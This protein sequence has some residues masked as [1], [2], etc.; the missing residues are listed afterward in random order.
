M[1]EEHFDRV[2]SQAELEQEILESIHKAESTH[3]G[4]VYNDIG[5][6][7][8]KVLRSSIVSKAAVRHTPENYQRQTMNHML[9]VSETLTLVRL[10]EKHFP[11]APFLQ[12]IAEQRGYL[13]SLIEQTCDRNATIMGKL[14]Q[15]VLEAKQQKP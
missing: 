6:E 1:T 10:Y 9:V 3:P 11:G 2:I 7:V 4:E 13:D 14:L 5:R 12:E 15:K 8:V